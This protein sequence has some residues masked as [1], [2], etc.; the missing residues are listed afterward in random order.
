MEMEVRWLREVSFALEVNFRNTG[1]VRPESWS[2]LLNSAAQDFANSDL[3]AQQK[4]GYSPTSV[5]SLV[6]KNIPFPGVPNSTIVIVRTEPVAHHVTRG[7]SEHETV[8]SRPLVYQS[9]NGEY[10]FTEIRED[11]LETTLREIGPLKAIVPGL[12]TAPTGPSR[13]MSDAESSI[14]SSDEPLSRRSSQQRRWILAF[15]SSGIFLLV[16][17]ALTKA[18]WRSQQ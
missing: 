16:L 11:S 9:T 17:R 10:L 12:T 2:D 1:K 8:L 14:R 18:R 7:G 15:A 6:E 3:V 4:F 5:Y 13:G